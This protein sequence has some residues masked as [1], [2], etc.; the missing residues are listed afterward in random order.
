MSSKPNK[1]QKNSTVTR[2]RKE[3]RAARPARSQKTTKAV[4]GGPIANEKSTVFK[5]LDFKLPT[6]FFRVTVPRN[7]GAIQVAATQLVANV[8]L[9]AGTPL[10]TWQTASTLWTSPV[11]LDHIGPRMT[12]LVNQGYKSWRLKRIVY[13]FIPATGFSRPGTYALV[14]SGDNTFPYLDPASVV[15]D[16][17]MP[18]RTFQQMAAVTIRPFTAQDEKAGGSA[19]SGVLPVPAFTAQAW[20]CDGPGPGS[21]GLIMTEDYIITSLGEQAVGSIY[22]H[23]DIE[24]FDKGK[25]AGPSTTTASAASNSGYMLSDGDSCLSSGGLTSPPR[26]GRT[27]LLRALANHDVNITGVEPEVVTTLIAA[28]SRMRSGIA[29]TAYVLHP[30]RMYRLQHRFYDTDTSLLT[31]SLEANHQRRRI[32]WCVYVP[33]Q[34]EIADPA[35]TTARPEEFFLDRTDNNFGLSGANVAAVDYFGQEQAVIASVSNGWANPPPSN[36]YHTGASST[37]MVRAHQEVWVY[38][39]LCARNAAGSA[40]S[41][42]TKYFELM[43]DVV[44]DVILP[45]I[46]L[47]SAPPEEAKGEEWTDALDATI[48]L[49]P[50]DG[51]PPIRVSPDEVLVPA[52]AAT[53]PRAFQRTLSRR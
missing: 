6:P 51:G 11:K 25:P 18:L 36:G 42:P 33:S 46:S 24:L 39:T 19:I 27:G 20:P 30:G 48:T 28:G 26:L 52:Q 17:A 43:L 53:T 32:F 8:R 13:Q 22:V 49:R 44:R 29:Q 2:K 12:E 4:G 1:R 37:L 34:S 10:N 38:P 23:V 40:A 14:L 31:A 35:R 47:L 50:I 15:N 9:P 16:L 21:I 45:L 7:Q 5:A 41:Y 3:R